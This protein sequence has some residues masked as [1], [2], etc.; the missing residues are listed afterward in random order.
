MIT[1]ITN[2]HKCSQ[3]SEMLTMLTNDDNDHLETSSHSMFTSSQPSLAESC[4][5]L[6]HHI[7]A[8]QLAEELRPGFCQWLLTAGCG[9]PR[10]PPSTAN[11]KPE[12]IVLTQLICQE[13]DVEIKEFRLQFYL[14]MGI[15][16][17]FAFSIC[18]SQTKF[19]CPT[20]QQNSVGHDWTLGRVGSLNLTQRQY[21]KINGFYIISYQETLKTIGRP[22]KDICS[23]NSPFQS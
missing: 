21:Q 8:L 2:A 13:M 7:D 14:F 12:K 22:W 23:R 17:L 10:S 3:L 6:G 4:L 5:H 19:K 20:A 9:G 16:A 1:M 11:K 18:F 15:R